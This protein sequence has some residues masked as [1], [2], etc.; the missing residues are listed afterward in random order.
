[1]T[2]ADCWETTITSDPDAHTNNY[3]MIFTILFKE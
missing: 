3:E 2:P 1:M